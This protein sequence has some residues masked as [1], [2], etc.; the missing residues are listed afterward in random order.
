[1]KPRAQ[2]RIDLLSNIVLLTSNLCFLAVTFL[3]FFSLIDIGFMLTLSSLC[4]IPNSTLLICM[5]C[6]NG[7][8]VWPHLVLVGFLEI[9]FPLVLFGLTSHGFTRVSTDA[10][11]ILFIVSY[12][13]GYNVVFGGLLMAN[14]RK[15]GSVSP[16][17]ARLFLQFML[18]N[19]YIM[20]LIYLPDI[21]VVL[22]GA[23]PLT[24]IEGFVTSC[25]NVAIILVGLMRSEMSYRFM[26]ES[27]S[28]VERLF[29]HFYAIYIAST[30]IGV[31]INVSLYVIRLYKISLILDNGLGV[32]IAEFFFFGLGGTGFL[33]A[34]WKGSLFSVSPGS[35]VDLPSGVRH[36][37]SETTERFQHR[38]SITPMMQ[39][40]E[41]SSSR[42]GRDDPEIIVV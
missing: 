17:I 30:L 9:F 33:T 13:G 19:A 26:D 8:L 4:T 5:L 32:L 42:G 39:V 20:F 3:G 40:H 29:N 1:M 28:M 2:H 18:S 27:S 12:I 41:S 14:R 34:I 21:S 22:V 35:T 36:S 25:I 6:F 24:L 31:A 38:P 10:V 11:D 16:K 23:R 15:L 7:H 37:S